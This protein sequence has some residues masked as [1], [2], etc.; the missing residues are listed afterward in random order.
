[1]E[2]IGRRSNTREAV[3]QTARGTS[4]PDLE[5]YYRERRTT[6]RVDRRWS[7][8]ESESEMSE[9]RIKREGWREERERERA[10]SRNRTG[11]SGREHFI[12]KHQIRDT[13]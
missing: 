8:V 9:R 12:K 6:R 3:A 2:R 13:A 11:S 4:D 10:K 5:P 7:P 1:M